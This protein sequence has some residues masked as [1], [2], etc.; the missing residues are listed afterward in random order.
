M[1]GLA[2]LPIAARRSLRFYGYV[3]H[4]WRTV[5]AQK[6]VRIQLTLKCYLYPL[7]FLGD[8]EGSTTHLLYKYVEAADQTA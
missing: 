7:I 3:I 6:A 2:I 5:D 4:S 8:T 1:R